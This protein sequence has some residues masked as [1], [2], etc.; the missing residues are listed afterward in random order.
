MLRMTPFVGQLATLQ[1][2]RLDG[3]EIEFI[4]PLDDASEDFL[5]DFK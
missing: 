4:V 3:L 5:R 2:A 1:D